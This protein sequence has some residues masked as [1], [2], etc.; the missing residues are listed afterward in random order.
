MTIPLMVLAF[1]SI[2]GGFIGIPEIF[3]GE[4]GNVFENW[5]EP[6][7]VPA[8]AKLIAYGNHSHLLEI[9]LMVI[10]VLGAVGAILF[11]R[12][13]YIKKISIA[14]EAK[15]SIKPYYNILLNKYYIDE[16][17]EVLFVK[18]I[19][20]FSEAFLWK[21]NDNKIIDGLVNGV[22]KLIEVISNNIR[23]IQTG[24]AQFYAFVM[25]AGIAA[26]L[27]WLIISL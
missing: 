21:I 25:V 14:E 3:S 23:K 17:Y 9:S 12:Y 22:A 6:V 18:S 11:A 27:F 16:I 15:Q 13:V 2:A 1:L 8:Q 20:R 7:F 4:H 10:S 19:N 26:A 5:L 24:V